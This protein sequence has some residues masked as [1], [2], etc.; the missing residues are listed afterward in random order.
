MALKTARLTIDRSKLPQNST[1]LGVQLQRRSITT[2]KAGSPPKDMVIIKPA[3]SLLGPEEAIGP[4][5]SYH[6]L[7][8]MSLKAMDGTEVQ[9]SGQLIITGQR[10]IGMVDS[11][12]AAGGA[13]LSVEKSGN[14][15]C[16]TCRR[17]DVYPPQ[18]KKRRLTP[19]DFTFRSKEEQTVA[20]NLLV[21]TAMVQIATGDKM[22]Y[23]QDKN[24]LHALSDEGRAKLLKS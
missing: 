8:G 13:P 18:V 22:E 16:F 14:V 2:V 19:S 7:C 15:F 11:G 4:E 24:M 3:G 6:I 1:D 17:D 10:L 23:W 5:R 21:I 20:F 9:G 12:T